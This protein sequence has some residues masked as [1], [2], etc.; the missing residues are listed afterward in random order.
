MKRKTHT[1]PDGTTTSKPKRH[2]ELYEEIRADIQKHGKSAK[3]NKLYEGHIKRGQDWVKRYTALQKNVEEL[4]RSQG[5]GVSVLESDDSE[6]GAVLDPEFAT[7]L[8]DVPV[9]CTPTAIAMFMHEKCFGE[10]RGKSTVDQ[11]HAAFL[12]HY[13]RMKGNKYHESRRFQRDEVKQEWVGN[14]V[15]SPEV[16]DMLKTCHNKDGEADRNHSRPMTMGDLQQ[17]WVFMKTQCPD[18]MDVDMSLKNLGPKTKW[19]FWLAYSSVGMTIW[20]RNNESTLLKRKN[21]VLNPPPHPS[22]KKEVS[23]Q[24][25]DVN[26]RERKGWQKKMSRNEHQMNGHK[27][28]IYPQPQTPWACMHTH[29]LNWI[30]HYEKYFLGPDQ[31][32]EDNDYI[33]PAFTSTW[34]TV[35]RQE[36]IS[37]K[38]INTL[39]NGVAEAAG[40]KGAGEFTTHC[41]RRGGA[42]YRFMYAP[43]GERWTLA[44][45]RWWGGWAEGEHRDTL[46]RYLLDELHTYEED[47]SDALCP[48]P[49]EPR[50]IVQKEDCGQPP[51]WFVYWCNTNFANSIQSIQTN[52]S[53]LQSPNYNPQSSSNLYSSHLH[54][55]T[56]THPPQLLTSSTPPSTLLGPAVMTHTQIAVLSS[57]M[58][59]APQSLTLESG[60]PMIPPISRSHGSKAWEIAVKDWQFPDPDRG[61]RRALKDWPKEWYAEID[62]KVCYGQ[63]KMVAE[64]FLNEYGGDKQAFCTA[65]PE[66]EKGF[67]ALLKAIRKV[68][69]VS[70]TRRTRQRG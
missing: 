33:F 40:V 22:G 43:I 21:I 25:F 47:H 51:N 57:P 29:L 17:I 26:L 31:H 38:S 10:G 49:I 6:A 59:Q 54:S 46:I 14:P 16:E 3:T 61:L 50:S 5:T 24:Y 23:G 56:P 4:W 45:I 32:L 44:R 64:E 27:F 41:F 28:R 70:G 7:C 42:Q 69:Q 60:I 65:Y 67:T 55:S 48:A 19:L 53:T 2:A 20:T 34:T 13:N 9:E 63:R 52:L 35:N 37:S 39:I 8:D 68:H 1:K 18:N 62:R 58:S 36:P 66:Y 11:V 12:Q 15:R 30:E